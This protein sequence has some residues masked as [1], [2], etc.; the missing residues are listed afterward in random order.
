MWFYKTT[1]CNIQTK[2]KLDFLL[3]LHELIYIYIYILDLFI[4]CELDDYLQY[5]SMFSKLNAK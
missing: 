5:K 2:S 3:F 4:I 1:A